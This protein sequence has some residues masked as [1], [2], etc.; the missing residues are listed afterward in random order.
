MARPESKGRLG[1]DPNP[2]TK[3]GVSVE[4]D[5]ER[6]R[7]L[8][9]ALTLTVLLQWMGATAIVPMLPEYIRH[10]GGSDA[11]AG[12]VMASF[13]AA[14]VLSQYPV[15]R[16]ADRIGRR[17][18]LM[19]GL[20]VYA[21]ASFSFLLPIGAPAA[22][23][24][25]ALQ[26]VGAGAA[27][28]AAL[29]MVSG[30]VSVE[31]RGRAFAAVYGGELAGMAVGPLVGSIVGV[32]HMGAM[33]LTA[34]L[35]SIGACVP[36]LRLR[37]PRG[38]PART[39]ADGTVLPLRRVRIRPSMAGALICGAALGL[40][41]GVY[42]ICWTLL[43]VARGASGVEIGISWTLFAVPFVLAAKPSGW[44]TDHMDRRV[45]V[46]A[47]VGTSTILCASYPFIH[48]VPVLILLG[49]S[50]ALGF[51][52]AMPAVQS[53][54]TQGSEPSEVGRVQGL[55]ATGQTACTALAA[56][57]AGAAFAVTSW[58]P[59][60]TVALLC[61]VGL[62]VAAVVWRSVP[63]RVDHA[64]RE[65][66]REVARPADQVPVV[67]AIGVRADVQ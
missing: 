9:R 25:R 22:V 46:L 36:A 50:E 5:G 44:L 27:T 51:A 49:A 58:L 2:G 31:R 56:A 52:A 13:F 59:F 1:A 53:L 67:E 35:L 26:G 29:A 64:V 40:T 37:E 23:A 60:V 7:R 47:G 6:S 61:G 62:G 17:P 33:F 66:S 63:G 19:A 45:L 38:A 39:S 41:T 8:I 3:A 11:L 18:V 4:V 14:G 34:G 20:V 42:E 54:L 55:F 65:S 28:V 12:L 43:L 30:S 21:V 24:L 16:L 15:G 10:L 32:A 48:Q 57:A